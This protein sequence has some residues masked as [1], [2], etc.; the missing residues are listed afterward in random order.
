MLFDDLGCVPKGQE[1]RYNVLVVDVV[2][3]VLV[4]GSPVGPWSLLPARFPHSFVGKEWRSE[5]DVVHC[6]G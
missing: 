6:S 2:Q 1:A 4:D 3:H 5:G